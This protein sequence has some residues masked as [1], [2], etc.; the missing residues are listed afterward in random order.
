MKKRLRAKLSE[1]KTELRR[2][3]TEP[4]PEQGAYLRSVLN[5]HARYYG[6]PGNGAA[7]RMFRHHL[8]WHWGRTLRRRG[9]RRTPAWARLR[10]HIDRWLPHPRICHPW[11]AQR[12]GVSTQGKS[13][14]R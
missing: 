7:L 9:N 4:I 1:V 13:R 12:L 10:R 14:M 8:G 6:V 2:R 11:P 3:M 5:G